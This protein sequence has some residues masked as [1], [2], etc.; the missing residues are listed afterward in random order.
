[1]KVRYSIG[2]YALIKPVLKACSDNHVRKCIM[3]HHENMHDIYVFFSQTKESTLA[4]LYDQ[5]FE[6]KKRLSLLWG[7]AL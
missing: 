6:G 7:G 1:M 2:G 5:I 3:Y 4:S